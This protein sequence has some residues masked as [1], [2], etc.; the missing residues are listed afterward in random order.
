[1][2]LFEEDLREIPNDI[3]VIES[4][5]GAF[6]STLNEYSTNTLHVCSQQLFVSLADLLV[7]Y[8]SFI[9]AYIEQLNDIMT[10]ISV[11]S[12]NDYLTLDTLEK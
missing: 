8:N 7:Y 10:Y 4:E 2:P 11:T 12:I 9:L 3:V 1:L 5:A 6:L